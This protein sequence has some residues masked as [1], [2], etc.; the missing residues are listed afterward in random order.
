MFSTQVSICAIIPSVY[1]DIRTITSYNTVSP[2][3]LP[4]FYSM[5][6]LGLLFCHFCFLFFVALKTYLLSYKTNTIITTLKFSALIYST[7]L[8]CKLRSCDNTTQ[9]REPVLIKRY[10]QYVMGRFPHKHDY[11]SVPSI[12]ADV[13]T[14]TSDIIVSL[15]CLPLPFD[16]KIWIIIMSVLL[17]IFL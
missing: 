6:K 14:V 7:I 3:C 10:T 4:I 1:V 13:K 12:C 9:Y 2:M 5:V 17:R 8:S 15:M 11:V 16:G